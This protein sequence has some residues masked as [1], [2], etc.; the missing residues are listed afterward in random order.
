MPRGERMGSK[1]LDFLRGQVSRSRQIQ[2]LDNAE[3]PIQNFLFFSCPSS[4]RK[5]RSGRLSLGNVSL[6]RILQLT[7]TEPEEK[8]A[9]CCLV[10]ERR[11]KLDADL[12]ADEEHD[13]ELDEDHGD[14]LEVDEEEMSACAPYLAR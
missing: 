8:V 7:P 9:P 2:D 11:G 14:Q 3:V 5:G 1:N 10:K 4:N 13:A 12:V 6:N